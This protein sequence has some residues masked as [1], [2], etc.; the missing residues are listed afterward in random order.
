MK[1]TN[2]KKW[3]NTKPTAIDLSRGSNSKKEFSYMLNSINIKDFMS[4]KPLT[5]TPDTHIMD[6]IHE[7]LV[8]KVTG[9]TVLDEQGRVVGIISELDLL[10][11][12]EQ[13]AYYQEGD[14]C[15]G[16]LMCTSVDSLP[17]ATT[18]FEAARTLTKYNRRRMPV[19]DDGLFVGQISCRSILQ[20]FKDSMLTHDKNED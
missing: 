15:I 19:V 18:L 4:V 13:I 16:D 2:S 8:R 7:M 5:F 9:G 12:L 14:A 11:K 10:N 20:A 6:A 3:R 17:L 1:L